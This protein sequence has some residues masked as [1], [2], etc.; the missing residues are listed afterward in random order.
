MVECYDIRSDE[1]RLDSPDNVCWADFFIRDGVN[2]NSCGAI[3][4][5]GSV[6]CTRH[7]RVT[8]FWTISGL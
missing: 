1:V 6:T 2:R 4:S 5:G 8:S 7:S 3:S